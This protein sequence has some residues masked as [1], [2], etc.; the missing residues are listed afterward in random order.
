MA[1]DDPRSALSPTGHCSAPDPVRSDPAP[2]S[3]IGPAATPGTAVAA[4]FGS[5]EVRPM[6]LTAAQSRALDAMVAL[7]N[8]FF[9]GGAAGICAIRPRL[10]PLLVG[11]TGAGKSWLVRQAVDQLGGN[12][13]HLTFGN[14]LPL[15]TRHERSTQ[16][17]IIDSLLQ[18][19]RV[20]LHVDE[21]DKVGAEASI[22]MLA[23]PGVPPVLLASQLSGSLP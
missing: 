2:L 22:G 12:L 11:P 16:F 8:L 1:T 14:W 6:V 3:S 5:V 20:V 7:G 10:F 15:G 13:L 17:T 19:E 4:G 23:A 9:D 18:F 21:L